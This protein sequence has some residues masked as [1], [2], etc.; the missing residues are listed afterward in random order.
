MVISTGML[1][2]IKTP[3]RVL[4]ECHRVLKWG[5]EAWI[6]DPARV[7]SQIDVGRFK[8][9]LSFR[10]RFVYFFFPLFSKINFGHNYTR[11]EI[12]DIISVTDFEDYS[13]DQKDEEIRIK[14]K[15]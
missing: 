5:G 2:T 10:E 8:A 15:K 3:A 7:A 14:L 11:E 12:V 9:S 13:I 1:H 6:Y 4:R